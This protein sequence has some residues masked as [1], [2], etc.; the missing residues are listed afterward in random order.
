VKRDVVIVLFVPLFY[1]FGLLQ[2]RVYENL[3]RGCGDSIN[4]S[5]IRARAFPVPFPSIL[6]K[7]A[8]ASSLLM[9]DK[10]VLFAALQCRGKGHK[11]R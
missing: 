8:L 7:T 5:R 2:A 9:P 11:S 3:A 1:G 6:A 4:Q 10:A